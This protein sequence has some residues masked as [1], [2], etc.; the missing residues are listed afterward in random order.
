MHVVLGVLVCA[1]TSGR[2]CL[3]SGV[4]LQGPDLSFRCQGLYFARLD[5]YGGCAAVLGAGR[6]DTQM[7][8]GQMGGQVVVGRRT[9]R[10][11]GIASPDASRSLAVVA[12][13]WQR[14]SRCRE[15][16]S[17]NHRLHSMAGIV[18]SQGDYQ[19]AFYLLCG[20]P[21]LCG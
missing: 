2:L 8:D 13:W 5:L 1:W 20:R 15:L 6:T 9:S 10:Q 7:K 4:V 11:K 18:A 3:G 14:S 16:V 21:F 17:N 19:V 12:N